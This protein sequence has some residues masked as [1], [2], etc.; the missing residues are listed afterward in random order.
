MKLGNRGWQAA[1]ITVFSICLIPLSQLVFGAITNDLGAD[2]IETLHFRTGDWALRFLLITLS[3]TPLQRIFRFTA[4]QRFR[5]MFG[6]YSFFYASLHLTVYVALDQSLSWEQLTD[7]IPKSPYVL[8]G[9]ATFLL[10]LPLALTS[11]RYMM[12]KLSVRW[13]KLHRLVYPAAVL[14]VIHFLWLVKADI[15]EPLIYALILGILFAVRIV[16]AKKPKL[17]INRC[18]PR[19][20]NSTARSQ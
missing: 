17:C 15:S 20:A 13:K 3:L 19:T 18:F 10:L 7:D 12:R 4:A 8:V 11:N 16:Y 1:K 2:P 6:L 9:L 5:R 14:A